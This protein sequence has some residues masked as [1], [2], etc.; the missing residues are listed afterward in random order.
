MLTYVFNIST[1]VSIPDSDPIL[2]VVGYPTGTIA[3]DLLSVLHFLNA[4]TNIMITAMA[5]IIANM[6]RNADEH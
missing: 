1:V 6:I 4:T 3:F 5:P 2:E